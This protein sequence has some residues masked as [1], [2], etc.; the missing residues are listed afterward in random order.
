MRMRLRD[1]VR[2]CQVDGTSCHWVQDVPGDLILDSYMTMLGLGFSMRV[3]PG[4]RR[5]RC[6]VCGRRM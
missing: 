2:R 1:S 3:R 5:M 6:R 4:G